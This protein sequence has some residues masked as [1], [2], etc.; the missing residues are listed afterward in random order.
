[1]KII[2]LGPPGSGKGTQ[3]DLIARQYKLP[4]ISTGD[5]FRE[6][7]KKETELGKK[8]NEFIRKGNLV[9]DDITVGMLKKRLEKADCKKGFI[10][11]GFPRTISQATALD[12]M[13]LK[14]DFVLNITSSDKVIIRRLSG[15][16]T[17]KKCGAIFHVE[18]KPP[19]HGGICD[20]CSFPLYQREDDQ[21]KTIKNR[22]IVY[23][24]QTE[25]LIKY[26]S[27]KG[28]IKNING[29]QEI[30]RIFEDVKKVLG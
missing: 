2:L 23:K 18:N 11:D 25:P 13:G 12:K 20:E 4:H 3:A 24:K 29:E 15:R 9:P 5:L 7:I 19:K 1:M 6:N 28:I 21:E 17:C 8:A 14:V 22:L 30:K 10:L 26:Y 16:R 27:K